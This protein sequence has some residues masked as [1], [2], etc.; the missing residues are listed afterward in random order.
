[1][2]LKYKGFWNN[3]N[4]KPKGEWIE[5]FASD[6]NKDYWGFYA[7]ISLDNYAQDIAAINKLIHELN[8]R[9]GDVYVH[10]PSKKKPLQKILYCHLK[11]RNNKIINVKRRVKKRNA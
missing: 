9:D 6:W 3:V 5:I 4:E 7:Y 2:P 11:T 1:M 10:P 8:W